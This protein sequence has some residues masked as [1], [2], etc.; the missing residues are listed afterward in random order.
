[1]A[2]RFNI[3][4]HRPHAW[5]A[6]RSLAAILLAAFLG[7]AAI[8]QPA[9][10]LS[11]DS[12]S[13][14][15][16]TELQLEEWLLGLDA[17]KFAQRQRATEGLLDAGEA[18]TPYLSLAIQGESL[19]AAE[20]AVWIL[21][22]H[23]EKTEQ[24]IKLASLEL[25]VA[26][27]RFP[28]ASRRAG[29]LLAA[30]QQTICQNRFTEL[31]AEMRVSQRARTVVGLGTLVELDTDREEWQGNAND[32][33]QLAKLRDVTAMKL[34]VPQLTDNHLNAISE[35]EGLVNLELVQTQVSFERVEE[36]RKAHPE[37]QLI[38]RG[39]AMLGVEFLT[40]GTLSARLVR[41]GMP[42]EKAGMEKGDI[43]KT[44]AGVPVHNFEEVTS[45]IARHA[46]GDSVEIGVLRGNQQITLTATL[47]K[48]NWKDER[49][50]PR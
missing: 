33:L 19:E 30:L 8:G 2:T 47:G 31:G 38:L 48:A 45:Q 9:S 12:E 36:I 27:K 16:P 49:P 46:P 5:V 10:E 1:M 20:R 24:P 28:E 35:I 39:G 13:V 29:P 6:N 18:A 3:Q 42:A 41:K 44:F 50:S 21:Q 22:Q 17:S 14:A 34:N 32:L 25:L 37:M 40:T 15:A 11:V 26:A 7:G 4:R 23:A 43:V